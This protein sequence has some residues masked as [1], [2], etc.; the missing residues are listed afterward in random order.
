[1]YADL[2]EATMNSR[3]LSLI[4]VFVLALVATGCVV[5]T[6]PVD[7][8]YGVSVGYGPLQYQGYVV[9]YDGGVPFYVA[10]GRR[11]Y[12]PRDSRYYDRYIRHYR[13]YRGSPYYRE[14][15]YQHYPSRVNRGPRPDYRRRDY[16]RPDYQ[17]PDY[18]RRDDQRGPRYR[19]P[20]LHHRP[21]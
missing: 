3:T 5:R 15:R 17:R 1:V 6:V 11:Y 4:P 8:S 20:Q 12:V 13:S 18:R 21:R 9:Y 19:D 14:W 16:R 7:P 2:K 10:D